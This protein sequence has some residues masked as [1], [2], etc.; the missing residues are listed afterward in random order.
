VTDVKNALTD[1]SEEDAHGWFHHCG[2][3]IPAQ[4]L[5]L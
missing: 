1:V 4:W 5:P 2:Y 3:C